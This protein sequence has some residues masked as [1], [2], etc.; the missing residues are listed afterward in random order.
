MM[1]KYIDW[2]ATIPRI[3]ASVPIACLLVY[4]VFSSSRGV[5]SMLILSGIWAIAAMGFA[6]ILRTGQFSL[7]QAAFMAIG[8]YTSAI[9]TIKAGWPFFPSFFMAGMVAGIIAM[10]IGAIILRVGGIYFSIITLAFGE[11]VRILAQNL[12]GLTHGA[13]GLIP[14]SPDPISLGSF[15]I[16]FDASLVPY[17]YFMII[18]VAIT[19]LVFWQIERSRLGGTFF[20]M[21]ANQILAEHQGIHLMKYRV[22]AFT[23][24]NIF[25]G[26]AGALYAHFLETITPR[27]LDL[28]KSIE[29]MIMGIV[30]GV[31][32]MVSGPIIG[33]VLLNG[34]SNYLSR[35]RIYGISQLL[36]GGAVVLLLVFLPKG[37]GLVDLWEKFWRWVF[38]E[39]EFYEIPSIDE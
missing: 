37:T 4:P 1:L 25:T 2:K 26:F 35:L 14:S 20:S 38:K 23:V 24:A 31:S 19:A 8:G 16:N 32:S 27:S 7:G 10:I 28:W 34:L 36:F 13:R 18:L 22:I 6:M 15:Q 30:G 11:I 12:E 5:L 33:A 9:L 17:Y 29:V 21:S 39:P 3:V